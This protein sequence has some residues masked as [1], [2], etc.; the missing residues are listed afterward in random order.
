MN[1]DTGTN[2]SWTKFIDI[3]GHKLFYGFIDEGGAE[4]GDRYFAQVRGEIVPIKIA[5]DIVKLCETVEQAIKSGWQPEQAQ[6]GS[7]KNKKKS[8]ATK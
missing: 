3:D 2:K 4:N 1:K 6:V 7:A 5:E 8:G